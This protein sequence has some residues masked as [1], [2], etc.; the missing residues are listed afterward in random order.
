[1]TATE[2]HPP[3]CTCGVCYPKLRFTARIANAAPPWKQ[4]LL[5]AEVEV[6]VR[7]Q[8]SRPFVRSS[9]EKWLQTVLVNGWTRAEYEASYAAFERR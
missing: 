6:G 3:T 4:K 5:G 1:V 9:A 7:D 8:S 2:Q